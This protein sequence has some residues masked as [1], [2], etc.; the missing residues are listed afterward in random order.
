M[1]KN[2]KFFIVF[3]VGILAVVG[4]VGY[5]SIKKLQTQPTITQN[6]EEDNKLA[7]ESVPVSQVSGK[8]DDLV[9]SLEKDLYEQAAVVYEED[10]DT[11]TVNSDNQEINGMAASTDGGEL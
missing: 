3:V 2:N 9:E 1:I 10:Q 11:N 7:D 4:V 5:F 8:V 6:Q